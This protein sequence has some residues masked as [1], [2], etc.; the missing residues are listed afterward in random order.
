MTISALGLAGVALAE[1]K[2]PARPTS[3]YTS[4]PEPAEDYADTGGKELT[5]GVYGEPHYNDERWVGWYNWTDSTRAVAITFDLG[6]AR[7]L[8]RVRLCSLNFKA[9]GINPIEKFTVSFSEDGTTFE[10]EATFTTKDDG[11]E[12]GESNNGK[13]VMLTRNLTGTGR[14]VKIELIQLDR[15]TTHPWIFLSE[16]E[17][18]SQPAK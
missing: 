7:K 17:F 16:V 9:A 8:S 15:S 12:N 10:N 3:T 1:P 13:T 4:V 5:D 2:A 14:W 18:D 6:E 11:R